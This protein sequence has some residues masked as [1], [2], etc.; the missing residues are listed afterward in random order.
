M[1]GLEAVAVISA[2]AAVVSAFNDGNKL[3]REIKIKRKAKKAT[4]PPPYLE[5]SLERGPRIIEAQWDNGF[6]DFGQQF[7]NGDQT[8]INRLKDIEIE[9]LRTLLAHLHRAVEDDT[10]VDF[11]ELVRA[12][13]RGSVQAVKT[14][15]ELYERLYSSAGDG[16]ISSPVQIQ[17]Q[18]Y[19]LSAPSQTASHIPKWNMDTL[20]S[21][22]Q[23]QSLLNGISQTASSHIPWG[24]DSYG[25]P[26]LPGNSTSG[27]FPALA[28]Q[29]EINSVSGAA[30][31][32]NTQYD[33]LLMSKGLGDA[34]T[35]PTPLQ[36]SK[37][38][39]N[40]FFSKFMRTSSNGSNGKPPICPSRS[41][42][43]F[44]TGA[45]TKKNSG[46]DSCSY[47]NSLHHQ[48]RSGLHVA[49]EG[50]T[51]FD[52]LTE[53]VWGGG[54]SVHDDSSTSSPFSTRTTSQ[55]RTSDVEE[56][57]S[58]QT[59]HYYSQQAPRII[60]PSADNNYGGFCEGAWRMQIGDPK[61]GMKRRQDVG[62]GAST[63]Y[64]W[65]CVSKQCAFEGALF[66]TKKCPAF[67]PKVHVSKSGV[68][69]RWSFLA[70]SH[71]TQSKVVKNQYNYGCVF[72]C[73]GNDPTPVF[74]GIDTLLEHLRSHNW[75]AI[76]AQVLHRAGCVVDRL[77]TDEEEF[78][79]NVPPFSGDDG[80]TS[81]F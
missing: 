63:Y 44:A 29:H 21:T 4:L 18:K 37:R 33:Q 49:D 16:N 32:T 80:Q 47:P 54:D 64:F 38:R 3:V 74:G 46:S 25:E 34:S 78:D 72:C 75:Q 27:T 39:K 36:D 26:P 43:S 11:T 53:N 57:E 60:L 6:R 10:M 58:H 13:N 42:N 15:C 24:P 50:E 12:S 22:M 20:S 77:C 67:N 61:G 2:V 9:L 28:S 48:S 45:A 31:V 1:S 55:P 40:S 35:T 79:I 62:P 68:R 19:H 56:V 65:K 7:A 17:A 23:E 14:L 51:D 8:A 59:N 66:G 41:D 70:K 5:E 52:E 30:L 76:P 69:F 81:S 73:T 71:I